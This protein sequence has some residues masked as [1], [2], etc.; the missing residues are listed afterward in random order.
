MGVVDGQIDPRRTVRRI[1]YEGPSD[2]TFQSTEIFGDEVCSLVTDTA[3]Y[4]ETAFSVF[5]PSSNPMLG[6][7]RAY[8]E[9][10]ESL[11]SSDTSDV[12]DCPWVY[13]RKHL[14]VSLNMK[15]FSY[16]D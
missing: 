7:L 15:I 3:I 14:S 2:S 12:I 16:C 8:L 13:A 11:P 6:R 5:V 4:R 1:D 10:A 9:C